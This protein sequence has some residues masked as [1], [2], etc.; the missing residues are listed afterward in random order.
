MN[1]KGFTVEES[2]KKK[3][4]KRI[5][6]EFCTSTTLFDNN[7]GKLIF[8]PKDLSRDNLA[9]K[10]MEVQKKLNLYKQDSS[11]ETSP[12]IAAETIRKEIK[13]NK[14]AYVKLAT[15]YSKPRTRSDCYTNAP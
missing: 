14:Q 2:T 4:G 5:K 13:S 9:I 10:V 8:L 6:D 1:G 11:A 15:A 12:V 3:L 7:E